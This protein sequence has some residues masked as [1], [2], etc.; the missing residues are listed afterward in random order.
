MKAFK[1]GFLVLLLCNCALA[2][3]IRVPQQAPT[4]QLAIDLSFDGDSVLVSP[5]EYNEVMTFQGK[6]IVVTSTHGAKMTTIRAS[7]APVVRLTN[8]EPVGTEFSGFTIRGTNG[9][10]HIQISSGARPTIKNNIFAEL[11]PPAVII[12]VSSA[13]ARIERNLFIN[14]AVGNACIGVSQF[15]GGLIANNTFDRNSRGFYS[16]GSTIAINNIITNSTE[17][18]VFGVYDRLEYNVTYNNH[19]NYDGGATAG[20]GSQVQVPGYLDPDDEDYRLEPGSVCI[21]SGDPDPE[22]NDPDGTRNDIGAYYVN[23]VSP[24]ANSMNFGAS[25]QGYHVSTTGLEFFWTYYDTLATTQVAYE[26]EIGTDSNWDVAETWSSGQI[27]SDISHALYTGSQLLDLKVYSLRI[28]VN[29]GSIWGEWTQYIFFTHDRRVIRVPED[30]PT[31]QSAI[32]GAIDGDTVLVAPGVYD[33]V[34]NFNGKRIVIISAEGPETTFLSNPSSPVVRF[35]EGEPVGSEINGFSFIC[36]GGGQ[37]ISI[38]QDSYP[39]IKNNIFSNL[40]SGSVLL[41]LGGEGALVEDNLFYQ[42]SVGHACI[43]IAGADDARIINNTFDR[44]S[45]GFYSS[46]STIAINNIVTNSTQYGIHG[47]FGV[48][49]YNNVYGN[50]ANYE[51]GASSGVGS[52]STS[53]MYV[54]PTI[55][56]YRLQAGSPCINTGHP[57][58]EYKDP[59][60]TQS[61]MGA[62]TYIPPISVTS[63]TILNEADLLHVTGPIPVFSWS[64]EDSENWGQLMFDIAVGTDNNWNFAEMWNPATFNS[65]VTSMSYNGAALLDGHEY[66]A[67]VRVSN[68]QDWSAWATIHFRLNSLPTTPVLSAPVSGSAVTAERPVLTFQP[69]TDSESDSLFYILELSNNNF[70]SVL[71]RYHVLPTGDSLISVEIDSAI[72]NDATCWWRVRASDYYEESAWSPVWSFLLVGPNNQYVDCTNG[73]DSGTG[74]FNDP[75]QTINHAIAV[76]D[77]SDTIFVFPGECQQTVVIAKPVNLI[78]L[79]GPAAT[80][81]RGVQGYRCIFVDG[82]VEDTVRIEGFTVTGGSPSQVDDLYY[83]GGGGILAH[84]SIVSID[85]CVVVDNV[86][87]TS[88]G[89][90]LFRKNTD[91]RLTNSIVCHNQSLTSSGGGVATV[92]AAGGTITRTAI[93]GNTAALNGGGVFFWGG[94]PEY[95]GRDFVMTNTIIVSNLATEG[96]AGVGARRA[97]L[98]LRNNIVVNNQRASGANPLFGVYASESSLTTTN[99]YNGVFANVAGQDYNPDITVGVH[100]LS[101]DPQFTGDTACVSFAL[102]PCSPFVDRGDP[103]IDPLETG[104]AQSDIGLSDISAEDCEFRSNR[105][106]VGPIASIDCSRFSLPVWI[107]NEVDVLAAIA[108]PLRWSSSQIVYDSIRWQGSRV[109]HWEVNL[110]TANN[111][112]STLLIGA[113]RFEA[114]PAS[115]DSGLLCQIFFHNQGLPEGSNV[116]FDTTFI[117]PGGEFVFSD[118]EARTLYPSYQAYCFD[119]EPQCARV[120]TP[121]GGESYVG[122][123]SETIAWKFLSDDVDSSVVRLSTD[124]GA[125]FNS[126]VQTIH[127]PDTSLAWY[128]PVLWEED[129]R[130]QV[131]QYRLGGIVEQDQSDDV[132][133]LHS[134]ADV[135]CSNQL[136]IVDVLCLINYIFPTV[137]DPCDCIDRAKD[138]NC[139]TKF[140]IVDVVHLVNFIFSGGAGPCPETPTAGKLTTPTLALTTSADESGDAIILSTNSDFELAAVELDLKIPARSVSKVELLNKETT[141]QLFWSATSDNSIKIGIIDPTGQSAIA[142]GATD[143]VR[144][145]L[146]DG[147]SVG[148]YSVTGIAVDRDAA[149]YNFT[150]LTTVSVLPVNYRLEQNQPNPFNPA[151]S[152][153]YSLPI[154]GH[155]ELTVFNIL[156]NPVRTLV[157]ANMPA[158]TYVARWD[159]RSESNEPMPSGVY[160]YRLK[161]GSFEE[162]KKMLLLK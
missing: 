28:R 141:L 111:S 146:T 126:V 132:F 92:D 125:T 157:D 93:A 102:D 48:L 83:N 80:T 78:S 25:A 116:C 105:V 27:Y 22:F 107:V 9:D 91:F 154:S 3:S 54:N 37:I 98:D 59:D 57:S 60:G 145:E 133:S 49:S 106:W 39:T 88:G 2:E 95:Y 113:T 68:D 31:I 94:T 20:I 110:A 71:Y 11:N 82:V 117:A 16:Y 66:W 79:D 158:G 26:I 18:G 64:W 24:A 34:V 138:V 72:A 103:S 129:C 46:G 135:D 47:T 30:K 124:G 150:S 122:H 52:I 55:A 96:G 123:H 99:D 65:T 84:Y 50:G 29:N 44:N 38:T 62:Y 67:R 21:D 140:N 100:S 160:F 69:S 159:G 142:V 56:D 89:G 155:V 108:V 152:I 77:T 114:A 156:G 139:D 70:A 115:P 104:G 58:A 130:I 45:R 13:G 137:T 109:D 81:I 15:G 10:A 63:L 12:S 6:R 87:E 8:G 131:T 14:N 35:E 51:G 101:A 1:V 119:F 143:L 61:D 144:V 76:A 147:H 86:A 121:N 148:E 43:G 149:E 151:T 128:V 120:N 33:G 73:N 53:P 7:S 85:N 41:L 40:S 19:P 97:D 118:L 127:G 112:N 161:S 5:G 23:Q 90:I 162:T 42:N 4:I 32:I 75:F 36:P 136:N 153:A 17:Y 134:I 74:R